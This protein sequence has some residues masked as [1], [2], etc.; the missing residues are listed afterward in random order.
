MPEMIRS[1]IIGGSA[2]ALSL[3]LCGCVDHD[4][5]LFVTDTGIGLNYDTKP[6]VA[7]IDYHRVEGYV[8]PTYGSGRLP[9]VVARIEANLDFSDPMVRQTYATGTAAIDLVSQTKPDLRSLS[10][11]RT[12]AP[13]AYFLT[14]S[15]IGLKLG[16]EN[17]T[18]PVPD[19]FSFGY[20]R[21]EFSWIP[22]TKAPPKVHCDGTAF[23]ETEAKSL[24]EQIDKLNSI[25]ANNQISADTATIDCYGSILASIEVGSKISSQRNTGIQL[26]QF[27]ATGIAAQKLASSG[28][29]VR[30]AFVS[31][32]S[33][34]DILVAALAKTTL[35]TTD[36]AIPIDVTFIGEDGVSIDLNGT[37]A[38]SVQVG[39]AVGPGPSATLKVANLPKDGPLHVVFTIPAPKAGDKIQAYFTSKNGIRRLIGGPLTV[40]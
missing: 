19:T 5:V 33:A 37:T 13:I 25:R 15:S 9:P 12:A 28:T 11:D 35:K 38:S 17:A 32:F 36:T 26:D 34:A 31:R 8:A 27:F 14:S 21:K 22:I 6:A 30:D 24:K 10:A 23:D 4:H 20:K 40:S 2:L 1:K 29:P 7:S 39:D 16:Y 18:S 3:A